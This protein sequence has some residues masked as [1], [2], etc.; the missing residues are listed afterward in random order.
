MGCVFTVKGKFDEASP[1]GPRFLPGY[2]VKNGAIV[3]FYMSHP[4]KLNYKA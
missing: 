4:F 1:I 2:A 3:G